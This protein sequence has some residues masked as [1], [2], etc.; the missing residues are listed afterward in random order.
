MFLVVGGGVMDEQSARSLAV[1]LRGALARRLAAPVVSVEGAA[2]LRI[3]GALRLRANGNEAAALA[4]LDLAAR[5]VSTV[6]DMSSELGRRLAAG[7]CDVLF[8][9]GRISEARAVAVPE[10]LRVGGHAGAVGQALRAAV[11]LAEGAYGQARR[12]TDAS[13]KSVGQGAVHV[14]DRRS[15]GG[16]GCD[17]RTPGDRSRR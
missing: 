1:A 2:G 6:G 12:L 15:P 17:R 5:V 7:R 4:E 16:A 13:R 11:H 10:M 9:V 8:D 3:D 14:D